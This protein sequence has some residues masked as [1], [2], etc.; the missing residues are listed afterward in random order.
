[1]H[2]DRL[3]SAR[4]DC[5]GPDS[6]ILL[7]LDRIHFQSF[8]RPPDA[9]LLDSKMREMEDAAQS[10]GAARRPAVEEPRGSAGT[11]QRHSLA[12]DLES[13]AAA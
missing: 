13:N 8:L 9:L 12:S 3:S 7:A 4:C 11:V 6:R 5:L 2:A 1:M 10:A